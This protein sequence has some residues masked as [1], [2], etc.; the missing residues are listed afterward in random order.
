MWDT[1]FRT[2]L[3][4]NSQMKRAVKSL[5][6]GQRRDAILHCLV[7][8]NRLMLDVNATDQDTYWW[9]EGGTLVGATRAKKFVP[10][11]D[12]ADVTMTA[13]SWR[14]VQDYLKSVKH[15][16]EDRLPK[17]ADLQCGCIILDTSSFGSS[18][19]STTPDWNGI[20]GRAVNECT[21]NY[22]DIFLALPHRASSG[23]P[24]AASYTLSQGKRGSTYSWKTSAI[25]PLRRCM[26]DGIALM[27]P[28]TSVDYLKAYYPSPMMPD[29]YWSQKR[30]AFVRK[31]YGSLLKGNCV[32]H[33]KR[34][35]VFKVLNATADVKVKKKR[36]LGTEPMYDE[37]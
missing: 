17:P 34:R 19:P 8:L 33:R 26:L 7:A 3:L 16:G 13:S 24:V 36:T 31:G 27:C 14:K 15:A 28:R 20:P 5:T 2:D 37:R 6:N 35:R 29:H 30:C 11:D 18:R 1:S 12:D 4:A 21:G 9:L 25:F 10:W 23:N 32:P 22:V